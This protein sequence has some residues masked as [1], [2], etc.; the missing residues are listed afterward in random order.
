MT[1]DLKY[2]LNKALSDHLFKALH[3][4]LFTTLVHSSLTSDYPAWRDSHEDNYMFK[5]CLASYHDS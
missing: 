2:K 4:P 1:S 5:N 3:C